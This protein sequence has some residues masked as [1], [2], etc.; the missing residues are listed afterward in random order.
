MGSSI[1]RVHPPR[2][3]LHTNMHVEEESHENRMQQFRL[4]SLEN[5]LHQNE[6]DVENDQHMMLLK[7]HQQN[8]QQRTVDWVTRNLMNVDDADYMDQ[9]HWNADVVNA[10]DK[11]RLN[12]VMTRLS[13]HH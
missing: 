6:F 10:S 4:N 8:E 11:K 3:M 2:P 12:N 9:M 13:Q 7:S 1:T 5:Y